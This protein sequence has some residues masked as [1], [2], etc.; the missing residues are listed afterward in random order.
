MTNEVFQKIKKR[1]NLELFLH[2]VF[3]I[4]YFSS[5]NVNWF[6]DWFDPSLRPKSPAPLV[7]LAFP[8]FFYVN[9]FWLIPKFFNKTDW[10]KYIGF[11]CLVFLLP[12]VI[13]SLVI[14]SFSEGTTFTKEI[15]SRDSFI[16]GSPSAF[17]ISLN[18]S[19]VYRFA[20]DWFRN[21]KK[22]EDLMA[23]NT[24]QTAAKPYQDLSPVSKEEADRILMNLEMVMNKEQPF[25]QADLTLRSL[26]DLVKTTDKKLSFVLNQKLK[27]N[28]Y[29]YLNKHRVEAFKK[30]LAEGANEKLSLVGI[31]LEC[32]FK[33]KSSFYR[34]FKAEVGSSP[35]AYLKEK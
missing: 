11:A 7:V 1:L 15:F 12:E 2:L 21:R 19:F 24:K 23:N 16:F 20:M 8:F 13:R 28:F 9:A 5:I 33:S 6:S 31:A 29:D 34:A 25:L 14:S 18:C 32:G 10:L 30:R 4:F 3:W 35:S 22:I 27:S 26:A 17:F